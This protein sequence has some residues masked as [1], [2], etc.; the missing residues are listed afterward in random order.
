MG[1]LVEKRQP[2]IPPTPA[3]TAP[4]GL[5]LSLPGGPLSRQER[6][7][8]GRCK[9]VG[10]C[11]VPRPCRSASGLGK[12]ISGKTVTR[13]WG[14]PSPPASSGISGLQITTNPEQISCSLV[15]ECNHYKQERYSNHTNKNKKYVASSLRWPLCTELCTEIINFMNYIIYLLGIPHMQGQY[16]LVIIFY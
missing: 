15:A 8:E 5:T 4:M 2:C 6:L 9:V 13:G 7:R 1:N 10:V 3:M 12:F 11:A 16:H 14:P